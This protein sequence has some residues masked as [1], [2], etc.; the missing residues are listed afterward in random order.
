MKL[1]RYVL[2]C[3]LIAVFAGAAA[4]EEEVA[5][6]AKNVDGYTLEIPN[7]ATEYLSGSS[8]L[9][10]RGLDPRVAGSNG[11]EG[12]S[13]NIESLQAV[14]GGFLVPFRSP[15]PA[16]SRDLLVTRDYGSPVQ[17]EPDIAVNPF[18]PDHLVV[19][20]IDYGFPS[21]SA[22][23]SYDGGESWEGPNQT[24]YLP[25]DLISGGDPVVA[26]DR[27]G[28]VYMAS[29]SIG[30]EEFAIGPVFS[31]SQVS[32]IAISRSDDGGFSWPQIVSTDR[33]KV[34]ISEQQID[35]NGRLRGTVN[36]GFLDKPWMVIGPDHQNRNR[37]AIYVTYIHFETFYDIVYMGELPLLNP[38]ELATTV[39]LVKSTDGGKTWTDPVSVSPT[40]RRSYGSVDTG[41]GPE[42]GSDRVLQGG[43]PAVDPNG[44]VYIAWLDSTDDG[45]M[46]G[47]GEIHVAKSTD[48]G[49]TF[50]PSVIASVFNEIPYRPRTQPFRF[51]GSSFP[52]MQSGPRG[53]LY[54]VY[55]ARPPEKSLDDGDI[56]FVRS[57]DQGAT[58]SK[59]IV[60][61]A[62][63]RSALQFFPELDVAPDGTLHVMWGDT[64][65]DP[66]NLRYHIYYTEST[67]RGE[68][69]GFEIEELGIREGDTRVS[70]FGSNPNRAFPGGQFL[71]D[72]FGIAASEEDVNMV[73]ADSRLAEFGGVNQK[74]AFSRKRAIRTPDIFISP[75]AGAGGEQITVQGFNFQP[76]MN[77]FIGLQDSTIA[78]AR[79]NQDGRFTSTI[80]IPVTGEGA[81]NIRAYDE[82]GNVA[83]TSFYTE[84]GFGNIKQ[85]YEDLFG[86]IQRLRSD[87]EGE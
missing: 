57:L 70:D 77:I 34:T 73:W 74:I 25:D 38:T 30:I 61:N 8:W 60:L 24:G 4:A 15:G 16:F 32:S 55:T 76:N 43:R 54:L 58:W 50:E 49:K 20:T 13:P 5:T 27:Q 52:R 69:W 86:E 68:T 51:W 46:E 83:F 22:Y 81:Q 14:G 1:P 3:V 53:E 84:F 72:Y 31:A 64:R 26:F 37:D 7:P 78:L 35:P 56:Y 80:Y 75:S 62:D 41:E 28:N 67:D 87:L 29:I 66:V 12:N 42:G 19:G 45:S 10:A 17:T 6:E 9:S 2:F 48:G 65:D 63:E 33:S 79:T 18:D 47:V 44:N 21:N 85:L 59:P 71:G 36:I 11:F 82:S 39:R 23:V 40:V